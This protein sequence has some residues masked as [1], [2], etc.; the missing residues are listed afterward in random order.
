M[1]KMSNNYRDKNC[2]YF[3]KFVKQYNSF[4][5]KEF[6]TYVL[7]NNKGKCGISELEDISM[8]EILRLANNFTKLKTN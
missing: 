5:S 4:W 2:C 8:P 7:K 1:M 3:Q 6:E